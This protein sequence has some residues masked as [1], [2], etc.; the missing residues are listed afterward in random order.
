MMTGKYRVRCPQCGKV[1]D[2]NGLTACQCGAQVAP[3]GGEIR[4]YRMGSPIGVAIG[5]GVYI[6]GQPFG[7]IGNKETVTY[8]VPFGSHNVH[9]TAG[10]SRKCQD[11]TVNLTPQAP[12]GLMKAHIRPGFLSNTVVIEPATPQEMP[13]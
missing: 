1:F 10:M 3:A 2:I 6:D 12:V 7:H 11:L 5:F 9:V 4:L 13:V 8:S